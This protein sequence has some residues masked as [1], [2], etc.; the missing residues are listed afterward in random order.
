MVL[1]LCEFM[2]CQAHGLLSLLVG[3][4]IVCQVHS[5]YAFLYC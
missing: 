4:F 1:W 5:V 2:D 3:V